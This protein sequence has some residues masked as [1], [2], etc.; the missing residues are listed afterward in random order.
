MPSC[1]TMS[2]RTSPAVTLGMP[3][4]RP[5]PPGAVADLAVAGE[6]GRDVVSLLRLDRARQA[7]REDH[8]VADAFDAQIGVRKHLPES[9]THAVEIAR[10]PD[11]EAPQLAAVGI[12]KEYA[13]LANRN[14]DQIGAPRRA[15]YRIG[16]P[17]IG[18]EH[19][20]DV[21]RQVDD[22]RLAD[23]ERHEA[24]SGL[25]RDHLGARSPRVGTQLRGA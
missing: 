16:D 5:F 12:E 11:V 20:L 22:D 21:R 6:P 4:A 14:A 25:A 17:G 3:R 8:A 9:R 2:R 19:I 1:L 15:D 7:A 18:H 24:G 13:G 23:A 10:H